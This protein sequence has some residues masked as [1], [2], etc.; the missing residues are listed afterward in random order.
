MENSNKIP[1]S[2]YTVTNTFTINSI[3]I[4]VLNVILN[5]SADIRVNC[6]D[7]SGNNRQTLFF[8]LA[9]DDYKLWGSEDDFIIN[10][11][12]NKMGVN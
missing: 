10:W 6:Y 9:D 4:S 11:V 2:D 12:K 7:D 8:K 1:I 3:Q 5:T